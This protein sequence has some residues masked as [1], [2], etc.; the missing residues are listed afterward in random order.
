MR[1]TIRRPKQAQS[2]ATARIWVWLSEREMDQANFV[3]NTLDRVRRSAMAATVLREY[4]QG[5]LSTIEALAKRDPGAARAWRRIH[6]GRPPKGGRRYTG[7]KLTFP[8]CVFLAP[9]DQDDF[10]KVASFHG[11]SISTLAAEVLTAY[12]D[13]RINDY[14]RGVQ[15]GKKSTA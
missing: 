1:S 14:D 3:A 7:E 15:D 13:R 9:E 4:A 11:R 2:P 12:L 10:R 5:Q 8:L 6:T